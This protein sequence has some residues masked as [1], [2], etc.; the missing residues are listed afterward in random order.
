MNTRSTLITR[1][2]TTRK[3]YLSLAAAI[4][5]AAGTSV[6]LLSESQPTTS[7]RIGQPVAVPVSPAIAFAPAT[8]EP[9]DTGTPAHRFA[10]A[11]ALQPTAVWGSAQGVTDCVS[12]MAAFEV[13]VSRCQSIDDNQACVLASLK[14]HGFDPNSYDLCKLF[15][16]AR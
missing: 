11:S 3:R 1:R 10:T 12:L 14:G 5:I 15:R 16:A 6:F 2:W 7:G 9:A 8:V 13:A 4:S